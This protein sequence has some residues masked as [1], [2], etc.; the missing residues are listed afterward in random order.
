MPD[1][2][3]P[4]NAYKYPHAQDGSDDVSRPNLRAG[5]GFAAAMTLP[6]AAVVLIV[7]S[8]SGHV[9]SGVGQTPGHVSSIGRSSAPADVTRSASDPVP[10]SNPSQNLLPDPDIFNYCPANTL[11]LSGPCET[12]SLEAINNAHAIEGLAPMVLPADWS[13]LSPS[14]QLFVATNLERTVRGLAPMSGMSIALDAAAVVGANGNTDASPPSGFYASHWTSNWAGGVGSPLEAVYLWMYDDGP[15]SPNAECQGGDMSGCWGHR[16]DI[17]SSFTCS[18]CVMGAAV[19]TKAYGGEPSWAELMADTTGNPGLVLSWSSQDTSAD[20][21]VGMATSSDQGYWIVTSNGEV[22]GFGGAPVYGSAALPPGE[23]VVGMAS[24]GD[25]LGY[26]EVTSNGNVF[27]FGDAVSYGT[28]TNIHLSHPIVSMTPTPNDGGYWLVASDGGVFSFGD[29]A[30]HGS[31]GGM[32]LNKPVVGIAS[33]SDGNG[34][35]LVASDGGIF[36]FGDA[37]FHGSTGSMKLNK[38]VVGMAPGPGG[39]GYW[40]VA[41]DGGIFSFGDAQFNG[42]TGNLHLAAPVVGMDS[43]TGAGYWLVASDGGIFSF[44]VPFH[45]SMA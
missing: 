3:K 12:A 29:A 28:A 11:D 39:Q 31:T 20:P 23:V 5:F 7:A 40:L 27:A 21:V 42:S 14:E 24:T 25:G 13:A 22:H 4:M 30:F 45:G 41:A 9:L 16:D 38:P 43:P 44:G 18:P 36:S 1:A 17:L 8:F 2:T 35:W 37:V 10:P 6:L 33:T 19:A 26:W 32:R 15:G 34:Y